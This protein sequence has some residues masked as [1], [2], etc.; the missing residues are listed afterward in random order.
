M[1]FTNA[2]KAAEAGREMRLRERVYPNQVQRGKMKQ[3]DADRHLAIMR[4]IAADYRVKADEEAA[5]EEK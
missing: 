1:T 2:E 4:E 3:P 5:K